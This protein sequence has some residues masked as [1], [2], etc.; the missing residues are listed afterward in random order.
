VRSAP[1]R[2]GQS[3]QCFIKSLAILMIF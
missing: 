3:K 1:Q 2:L